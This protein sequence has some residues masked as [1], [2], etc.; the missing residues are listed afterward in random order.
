MEKV[1]ELQKEIKTNLSQISASQKDENRI[2]RA[3]LN[4]MDYVVDVYGKE[5][6]IGTYC[7]AEDARAMAASIISNTAKI[8]TAEA[9]ELA[10]NHKFSKAEADSMIGISKEFINTFLETG[11]K[12]PL[13]GRENSNVSLS[14][15]RVKDAV[16]PYNKISGVDDSGKTIYEKASTFVPAHNSVKVH[17][18]CPSWLKK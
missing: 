12:L 7:P 14:I 13:G 5:G 18:S 15:K 8:P 9:R 1:K 3:M 4:D 17:A 6:K 11:R 10:N 16:K 2:M